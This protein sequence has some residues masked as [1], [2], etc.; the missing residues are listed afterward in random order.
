MR[1]L[2]LFNTLVLH[3]FVHS[4]GWH[5]EEFPLSRSNNRVTNVC[6]MNRHV[7]VRVS[8]Q[9][10]SRPACT[11]KVEE[12]DELILLLPRYVAFGREVERLASLATMIFIYVVTVCMLNHSE[13]HEMPLI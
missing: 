4:S 13:D 5:T 11:S 2:G 10:V 12:I 7:H 1:K 3:S 6:D 8:F 9:V